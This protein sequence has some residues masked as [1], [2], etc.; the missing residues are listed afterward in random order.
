MHNVNFDAA[1]SGPL[2]HFKML[3][4]LP[5]YDN[6]YVIVVNDNRMRFILK[7][8]HYCALNCFVKF[9]YTFASINPGA[10]HCYGLNGQNN[11]N[12]TNFVINCWNMED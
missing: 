7:N 10:M 4:G 2:S 1:E 3:P 11:W 12:L 6:A 9:N 8:G 5:R